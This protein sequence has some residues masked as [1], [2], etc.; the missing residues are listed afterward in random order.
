MPIKPLL[1]A[2][3]AVLRYRHHEVSRSVVRRHYARWREN[4]GLPVRCDNS[5]CQFFSQPLIWNG[6]PL[7]P[8]LDHISGNSFDNS[9]HNLRLLCPNCESQLS[10]RG[11]ANAG[12]LTERLPEGF[13][14]QNK[15]GTKTIARAGIAAAAS[16]A[17]AEA[18]AI[19][20]GHTEDSDA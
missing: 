15:D 13:T 4:Q 5:N 11:G 12:R 6:A 7:K 16:T 9:P 3:T 1:K 19:V 8:I 10:T 2:S 17:T 18:V 20:R 14:L